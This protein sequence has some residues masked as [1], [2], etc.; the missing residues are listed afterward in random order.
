MSSLQ[1]DGRCIL[2]GHPVLCTY[3]NYTLP[4]LSVTGGLPHTPPHCKAPLGLPAVDGRGKTGQVPAC[5]S[6]APAH[7]NWWQPFW[8]QQQPA[9]TWKQSGSSNSSFDDNSNYPEAVTRNRLDKREAHHFVWSSKPNPRR[10][11]HLDTATTS[12]PC[13]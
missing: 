6:E 9:T 2:P 11:P 13:L 7:V 1:G 4:L 12:P 8:K 5:A 3:R 10:V